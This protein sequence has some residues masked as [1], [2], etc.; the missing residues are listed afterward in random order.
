LPPA[1]LLAFS[2]FWGVLVVAESP[3]VSA[4]ADRHAPP[5]Y[6]GTELTVQNGL[7]FMITTVSIQLLPRTAELVS[8][9]W[10]LTLLAIGPAVGLL[11]AA[12]VPSS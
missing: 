3:Q 2:L 1:A 10:T 11:F 4:L 7:G 12:R 5:E 6:T 8:W 9:Q